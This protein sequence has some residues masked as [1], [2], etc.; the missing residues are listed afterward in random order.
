MLLPWLGLV[1]VVTGCSCGPAAD[2]PVCQRIG[3]IPVLFVGT[4]IETNDDYKGHIKGGIWY[5]FR[6][7]EPFKG[8]PVGLKEVIVDPSSG[9]S[10]QTSFAVGKQYLL[11]GIDVTPPRSV[12]STVGAPAPRVGGAPGPADTVFYTGTCLRPRELDKAGHDIAFL[13]QFVQS[14]QPAKIFGSVRIHGNEKFWSDRF[15]PLEGVTLRLEGPDGVTTTTSGAN[16]QY[17]FPNKTPGSYTITADADSFSSSLSRYYVDVPAHGCG[18]ANIGMFSNG[19]IE[20]RVINQDGTPAVG[21]DVEYRYAN[22]Q[23]DNAPLGYRSTTTDARGRFSLGRVPP[24]QLLLG[25]HVDSPPKAK[26]RIPPTYWPGTFDVTQAR[27]VHL[28]ANQKLRNVT[29]TLGPRATLRRVTVHVRRPDGR[30]APGASVWAMV[31]QKIAESATTG[32]D[33]TATLMLLS[34][35]DYS[36]SAQLNRSQPEDGFNRILVETTNSVQLRGS[37][38]AAKVRLL[39]SQPDRPSN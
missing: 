16:G 19:S 35:L 8:V 13:R 27:T 18:V 14:P 29:I 34:N 1:P 5:R 33:G 30:P 3:N 37:Q 38:A 10:C 36:F 32:P 22:Q 28:S 9:S 20:G 26:E 12:A 17:E 25:I 31:R 7:D 39:L 15:P 11:P 6:I 24:G 2:Q 23:L 21:I 4:V